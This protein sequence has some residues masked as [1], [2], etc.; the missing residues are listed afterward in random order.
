MKVK[1]TNSPNLVRDTVTNAIINQDVE[2]FTSYTT[3]R[4]KLRDQQLKLD[5]VINE[6]TEIKS[7]LTQIL[8]QKG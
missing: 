7:L 5:N 3:Q 1:V 6:M 2:G 4:T 8:S